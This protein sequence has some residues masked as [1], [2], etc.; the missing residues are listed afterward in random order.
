LARLEKLFGY[1]PSCIIFY[2]IGGG[3]DPA[4]AAALAV[5]FREDYGVRVVLAS[6]MWE[7][8]VRDP[9]PGPIPLDCLVG[10][11]PL[12]AP[13]ARLQP[14]CY[15]LREGLYIVPSACRAAAVA[16]VPAYAVDY[17]MGSLGAAAALDAIASLHGCDA[18][19]AV[20]VGGDVLA[21]GCEEELWSPLADS[22]GLASAV[23]S[24]LDALLAVHSPGA[25]GELSQGRVLQYISEAAARGGYRW[26]RGIAYGEMGL[27]RE[28]L[29]AIHTE[30][31]RVAIMAVE[32]RHGRHSIRMGSR[33]I[34][35]TIV[36]AVT[37]LLDARV[38]LE[39]SLAHH[40]TGTTSLGE[41]RRRL[42]S[43]G[44]YTELD[45]EEDLHRAGMGRPEPDPN[46]LTRVRREGRARLAPCKA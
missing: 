6:N 43:L 41:A 15:A 36:N 2:A 20:D 5:S 42:N 45:L 11:E 22:V 39:L 35:V 13:A 31:G 10:A 27:W 28:I 30:A 12:P 17:W 24:G 9:T 4:T 26:A 7:R 34:E 18:V 40:V 3:G 46:L 44:V 16:G 1:R 33:S 29:E 38:A 25:D 32:G 19:V 23:E 8:F 37:F 14:G 21:R